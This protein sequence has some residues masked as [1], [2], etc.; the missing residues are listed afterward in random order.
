MKR[1]FREHYKDFEPINSYSQI[2]DCRPETRDLMGR[3]P[4]VWATLR[5]NLGVRIK[6]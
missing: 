2:C 4:C 3:E 1:I 5:H 6:A